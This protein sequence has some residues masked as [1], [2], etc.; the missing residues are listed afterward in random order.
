MNKY[1]V[2]CH[3]C[4]QV[5]PHIEAGTKIS[6]QDEC[7]NCNAG[8]RCCIMCTFYDPT[9]YNECHEHIAERLLEKDK[10]N[11]CDYFQLS[12]GVKANH[13]TKDKLVSAA[14]ALFKK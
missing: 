13:K 1:S 8:L 10:A 14:D 5:I 3:A 9:A 2:V 4:K 6:R 12:N 11:F 7:P